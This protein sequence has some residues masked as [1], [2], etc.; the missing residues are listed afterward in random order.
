MSSSASTGTNASNVE[1]QVAFTTASTNNIGGVVIDFCSN[2]P[3]IGDSCTA[4]GG[5]SVNKSTNTL[6]TQVGITGLSIDT[7]NS[8]TNTLIMTRTA[9]SIS[10]GTAVTIPI[11]NGTTTGFTN[12]NTVGSFYARIYTY[13]TVA[14]AQAHSPNSP[15]NYVDY[16]GIALST[17]AII[18]ITAKVQET[19]S[20]C[21]YPH[22]GTCG[23]DPSFTIG[24]TV[25]TATVIDS[26]VVDTAQDDFSI[27]TNASNGVVVRMKGDTLKSGSN[28]IP[29]AGTSAVTFVGGTA[30]FGFRVST[31][32]TNITATAPYNGG[33]GTQYGLDVTASNSPNTNVTSTFGGQFATLSGPTNNSV[34]TLEF[35]AT[36]SN[37]TPAGT[38]TA[39]EQLIATGTF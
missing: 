22:A 20:F 37:T 8:T 26:S 17:V 9:S 24:H 4:P 34:S 11:G 27:S 5:F 29:A 23:T 35:A 10:S 33:T 36:A 14:H 32:G 38:Y 28:T 15:T 16:G 12:P 7:T 6:G 2:D 3:I 31:S 21:V 1:Y 19:L 18:N 25:G 13:D 39:A 30:K